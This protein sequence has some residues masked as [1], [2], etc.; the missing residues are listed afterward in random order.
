MGAY[1]EEGRTPDSCG[2]F[3]GDSLLFF[4]KKLLDRN[5]GFRLPKKID[6]Q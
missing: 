3:H 4:P 5:L 6:I 2:K 1:L